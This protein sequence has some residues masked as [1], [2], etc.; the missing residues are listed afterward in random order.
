MLCF[1]HTKIAY[2]RQG[3]TA[4]Y[5]MHHVLW[6][7]QVFRA[8]H[9]YDFKF[10]TQAM[11]QIVMATLVKAS[12]TCKLGAQV[13]PAANLKPVASASCMNDA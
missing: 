6:L 7:M 4:C 1:K 12:H 5:I 10:L 11:E 9:Q 13:E 3:F 2:V 8:A